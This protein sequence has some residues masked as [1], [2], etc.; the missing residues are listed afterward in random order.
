MGMDEILELRFV[1]LI[2]VRMGLIGAQLE[3]IGR[4]K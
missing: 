1:S 2:S 3:F 4:N